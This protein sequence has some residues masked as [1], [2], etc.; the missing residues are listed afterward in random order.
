[1]PHFASSNPDLKMHV[2]STLE[3]LTQNKLEQ[4]FAMSLSLIQSVNFRNCSTILI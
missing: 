4:S 1:M 2:T 3:S